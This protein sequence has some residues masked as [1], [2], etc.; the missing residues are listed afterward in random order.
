MEKGLNKAQ[1]K[2]QIYRIVNDPDSGLS[3]FE[4]LKLIW[5]WQRFEWLNAHLGVI[6]RRA[7]RHAF[8]WN[9]MVNIYALHKGLET[10]NE[11]L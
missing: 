5:H 11:N 7:K 9:H 10:T 1:R 8:V 2:A 3:V 6:E 4:E